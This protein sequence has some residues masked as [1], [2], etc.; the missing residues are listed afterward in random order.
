MNMKPFKPKLPLLMFKGTSK[1]HNIFRLGLKTFLKIRPSE[2][3]ISCELQLGIWS[4]PCPNTR[5]QTREK[6]WSLAWRTSEG[7]WSEHKQCQCHESHVSHHNVWKGVHQSSSRANSSQPGFSLVNI[8]NNASDWLGVS[9]QWPADAVWTVSCRQPITFNGHH[10][11]R[12]NPITWWT[13]IDHSW[14]DKLALIN[15]KLT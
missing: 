11:T 6:G 15:L 14:L 8:R 1:Y 9:N 3:N 10:N 13:L 4:L 12:C 7:V 5:L 2:L